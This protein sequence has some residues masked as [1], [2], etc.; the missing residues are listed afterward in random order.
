[1]LCRVGNCAS[2]MLISPADGSGN[3]LLVGTRVRGDGMPRPF[4]TAQGG[5]QVG[6]MR[7]QGYAP[8]DVIFN[9]AAK[10][11]IYAYLGER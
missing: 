6:A 4:M 8:V 3:V 10:S 9:P 2:T 1:M 11:H 5:A 7:G